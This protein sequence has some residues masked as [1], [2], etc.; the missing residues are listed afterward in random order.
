M[1]D[2]MKK[3]V[4]ALIFDVIYDLHPELTKDAFQEACEDGEY[5]QE[6]V[7]AIEDEMEI[8]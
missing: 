4:N 5:Y 8:L 7:R 3:Q 6:A 2:K 1:T